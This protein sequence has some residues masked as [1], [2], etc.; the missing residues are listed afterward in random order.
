[1]TSTSPL[2][3]GRQPPAVLGYTTVSPTLQRPPR[4]GHSCCVIAT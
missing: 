2:S 1:L 3:A 4:S